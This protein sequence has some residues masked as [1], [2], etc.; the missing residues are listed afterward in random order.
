M[1]LDEERRAALLGAKLGALVASRRGTS[2]LRRP[3]HFA[4]GAGLVLEADRE[5]EVAAVL[6]HEIAHVTQHHVLRGVER[7]Q[8]DQLPILLGMLG[9]VVAAQAAGGRSG[10]N[11]AQ[12]AIISAMGLAQQRQI[13]YTRSNEHEADRL[14]IQTLS[15][16]RYDT[17]AMA[18]FFEKMLVASRT[19]AAGYYDTPD[20]LMTHPVTTTRI[21]EA[22]SRSQQIAR[23]PVGYFG[24]VGRSDNPLLPG[25]FTLS[26]SAPA[27]G[28]TGDFEFARERLRVLSADTA[29][30]AI[31]EYRQLRAAGTMTTAQRYGYA[32]ALLR[33]NQSAAAAS[34]LA[35]LLEERPGHLWLMLALGQAE[36]RAG[37]SETADATFTALLRQSPHNRAVALTYADVL[38]ERNTVEAGQRAQSVLRPLLGRSAEDAVFQRTF[39]RASDIAG[40]PVRAGEA[41]AEA[42][43]LSG[44]AEQALVQLK[45]LKK[46]PEVD[47]YAR[48]RIEARIAA[49]TP[50]VLELRRQGIRDEDL[51]RR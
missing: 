42:A 9:A 18:D 46:R 43:F 29:S 37:K 28:G 39:A 50:I 2:G 7:A 13:D 32:I 15:R 51:R 4:A 20:Y 16:S 6:S 10:D 47:Y 24:D 14:G 40:D 41:H 3:A 5:D 25:G 27:A 38:A 21:G 11:A 36:A 23:A 26:S 1:A 19:N 48:A 30:S 34:E 8:K 33:D 12:A 44:R 45:T 22:K 35:G 49:I 17:Q 31:R